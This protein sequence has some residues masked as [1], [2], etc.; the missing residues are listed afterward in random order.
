MGRPST[1]ECTYLP[2]WC[3]LAPGLVPWFIACCARS[4]GLRHPAVAVAWHLSVCL[5]YGRRPASLAC[6]VA[7]HDVP[8]LVRSGH[9]RCSSW[10][11]RRHGAFPHPRGLRPRLYWVAAWGTRRP[12]ENRAHCACCW[13]PPRQGRAAPSALYP[14][15]APRWGC[16]WRVPPSSVLDCVRCGGW[17]VCT[18]S[19]TCPVSAGVPRST[20]NS[21]GALGLFCVDADTFPSGSED[22]T[23]WSCAGRPPGRVLVRLTFSAGRFAFLLYSAPLRL[24]LPLFSFL[25][26]LSPRP[27][28]PFFFFFLVIRFPHSPLVSFFL[29]LPAAGTLG[30]G[31][32]FFFPPP[33]LACFLFLP[34]FFFVFRPC[35]LWLSLVSG[36]GCPGPWRCVLFVLFASSSSALCALSPLLCFPPGR[37]LL[38]PGGCCPPSLPFWFL[39]F[40][41]LWLCA[42]FLFPSL[43]G[44]AP[45]LSPAFSGSRPRVPWA[46]VLCAVCFVGLP[47]LGSPCALAFFVFPA[48]PLAA[49]WWLLHPPP[50]VVS[51][52][53]RRCRSF[54][55]FFYPSGC[56]PPLSLAFF[57]FRPRGP[58]ALALCAVCFVGLPLFGSLCALASLCFPLGRCL[59]TGGCP[60]PPFCVSQFLVAVARCSFFFSLLV[61][62]SRRLLPPPSRCVCG[63]LCCLVSPRCAALRC[64]VPCCGASPCCIAGCCVLCGICWGVCL[65]VVLRCGLLPRVVPCVWSWLPV[66]MFA[67]TPQTAQIFGSAEMSSGTRASDSNCQACMAWEISKQLAK[68]LSVVRLYQAHDLDLQVVFSDNYK[69]VLGLPRAGK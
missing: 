43:P 31:A 3:C 58:W 14:F 1:T 6:L 5:G 25:G 19:L 23:P 52:G 2:T 28:P 29:W 10:L 49:L 48:W 39:W 45:P 24:R 20:G 64:C 44:C 61:G 26:G 56:A 4:P 51:R 15:G 47:L 12:A 59:L 11:S 17:R 9:S 33:P 35:C 53:F 8:G 30:L 13:P 42:P 34:F 50:R 46:L 55:C 66:R 36:P 67:A 27:P 41:S 54:L 22:A 37:W 40:S 69:L 62:G 65:C 68:N 32:L 16:P 21:A 60:P 18:Q 7:P 63:A 57:N 38:L